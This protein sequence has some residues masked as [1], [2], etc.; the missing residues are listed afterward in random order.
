VSRENVEIV[1]QLM[2][3]RERARESGEPPTQTD[4]LA[5]DFEIDLSRRVFNPAVYRGIDGLARLNDEIRDVWEEFRVVP[6][7]FIEA[8]DRV[9][10]IETSHA[11]GRGS[12]VELETRTYATIW[13]L[14]D[15]QVT[16]VQVGLDTNEALKAVGLEE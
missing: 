2:A 16:R 1:R 3:L 4:L 15:G 14:R 8:G 5:P 13:T 10:V 7:Q 6:E 11:R 9:V 12:G